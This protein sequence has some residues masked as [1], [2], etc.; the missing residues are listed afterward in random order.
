[1]IIIA[2]SGSTKTHWVAIASDGTRKDIVSNGINPYYQ[3]EESIT[4]DIREN[5]T[6]GT[7]DE[8]VEVFFYGAGCAN[9]EKKNIVRRAILANYPDAECTV[10]SD[11]TGACHSLLKYSAGIACIL[12]TGSNS[13][14]YDGREIVANVSPLGFIIGDEG[15]GAVIGKTFIGDLL[16][17][18]TTSEIES[19]FN[20]EYT[21]TAGDIVEAVYR[22]SFP[23][24]FLAQFTKFVSKALDTCK[25]NDSANYLNCM[26]ETSFRN[27]FVR[28]VSQYDGKTVH[29]VGSIA[30]VF[31]KQLAKAA[32]DCGFTIGTI[33]QDPIEGLIEYHTA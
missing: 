26:L 33:V 18:Q 5:V 13:C 16:K 23:N 30:H 15:S 9:D 11:L 24:R 17:K 2:D 4:N 8:P 19:L 12:G 21:Y 29:F 3:T 20:N 32:H 14:Y 1:M 27:F 28:N 10:E 7:P 22:K 31:R 6:F 25:E